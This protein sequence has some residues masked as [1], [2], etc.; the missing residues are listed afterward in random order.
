LPFATK[1]TVLPIAVHS[2]ECRLFKWG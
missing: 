1:L 2:T